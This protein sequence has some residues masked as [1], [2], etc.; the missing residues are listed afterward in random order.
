[1]NDDLLSITAPITLW[2]YLLVSVSF[3]QRAAGT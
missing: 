1:M 3:A 2:V